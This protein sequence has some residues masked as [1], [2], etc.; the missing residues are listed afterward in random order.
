MCTSCMQRLTEVR[1]GIVSPELELL[2]VMRHPVGAGNWPRV[3]CK[4]SKCSYWLSLLSS[5]GFRV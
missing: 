5:P 4:G 3:L 1:G 2:T